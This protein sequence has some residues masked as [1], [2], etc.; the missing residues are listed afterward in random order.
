MASSSSSTSALRRRGPFI[1]QVNCPD[2]GRV[3]EKKVSGMP[4]HKGWTFYKCLRHGVRV[5]N[6]M[7]RDF[8]RNLEMVVVCSVLVTILTVCLF[9]FDSTVV[10]FGTGS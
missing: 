8:F 6:P 5:L 7:C 2:C 4:E 9:E 10:Y 3:V 1:P